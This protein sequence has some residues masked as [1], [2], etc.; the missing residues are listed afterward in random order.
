MAMERSDNSLDWRGDPQRRFDEDLVLPE[1]TFADIIAAA[2][3][4][5]ALGKGDFHISET[6]PYDSDGVR[7]RYIGDRE[8]I[9][10]VP[11]AHTFKQEMDSG[12]NLEEAARIAEMAHPKPPPKNQPTS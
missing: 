12:K 4:L 11:L 7:V 10:F 6:D 9:D 1:D 3:V 2:N 8:F 5:T